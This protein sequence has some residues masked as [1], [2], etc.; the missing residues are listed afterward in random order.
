MGAA[1]RDERKYSHPDR[2]DIR[3]DID[4]FDIR[5]DIGNAT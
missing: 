1:N 2:F 4:R 3:R 5:R